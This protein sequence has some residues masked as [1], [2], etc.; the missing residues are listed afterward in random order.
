M[1]EEDKYSGVLRPEDLMRLQQ[2]KHAGAP[3]ALPGRPQQNGQPK[4]AAWSRAGA[5]VAAVAGVRRGSDPGTGG[6]TAAV[7]AAA[8]LA[9][10]NSTS[11]ALNT[12]SSSSAAA[13]I[14]NM[15]LASAG[16][17]TAP[18]VGAAAAAVAGAGVG[19]SS[20]GAAARHSAPSSVPPAPSAP[21]DID[22]RQAVN[23]LRKAMTGVPKKD[24]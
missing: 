18:M 1:D 16:G 15:N 12:P 10:L 22:A 6:L 7:N 20:M 3:A 8:S 21:I 14:M 17:L 4:P 13:A 23:Q 24:R 19:D 9:A 11:A 5:G 2:A